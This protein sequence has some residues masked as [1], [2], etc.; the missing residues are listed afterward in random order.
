MC[1]LGHLLPIWV[2]GFFFFFFFSTALVVTQSEESSVVYVSH[3]IPISQASPRMGAQSPGP[4]IVKVVL[5]Q[6]LNKKILIALI[7]SSSLLCVTVMFL[8]YLL[9]WRYRNMKNSFTGIKRNSDSVKSVTTKPIVHKIDSVRKGTIPVYEFQLLESATNKFS[10]SNVLSR[11]G[12]GCLYRACLDE[13][14]SVTVKRLDGGGETDIE[15]Q[16]ETEVDWLAKIRHQNIISLLGFCVYRQTSCIV[17][18]MMQN[19][20]LESQLHGPSQGSGLTWQLRMKIAV[21]IARGLEYLHEH[22]HPPVVHRDLKSSSI[23]LDS[24][25]NAKISD[26]GFAT[27]LTTQNKNLI[28]KASEH[29]LDGKVTDKNDVYSFGVI[30]LEL[31]LGKKSGEKPSS[32][33]ESI[34]T[35]AVPK[36]SDRAS[37]PNILD[38]AIKGTMDLKHL[39]QVAAV[40]VLCVQPEPSYRPLITDVLHSLIPLLPVELGGSLRIL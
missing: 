17:Y 22:C 21:D 35:W 24:D 23:L 9:L 29:L 25:F 10:D 20:S 38:P 18:E 4:P 2:L 12:R 26:F 39:Y 31:L 13:K 34:V 33:P 3:E 14:S 36:L 11:G 6:D 1:L 5:R 19:G 7:V 16:F 40:A 32:E 28:H 37:L 27:V 15:K 8:L 30:L